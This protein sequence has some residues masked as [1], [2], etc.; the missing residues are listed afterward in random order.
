MAPQK[1][2]ASNHTYYR[3]TFSKKLPINLNIH[4]ELYVMISFKILNLK[5]G[6]II[7]FYLSTK[8]TLTTD[9]DAFS[10]RC[11]SRH[12]NASPSLLREGGTSVV[13]GKN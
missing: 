10:P 9:W 2:T 6:N 4:L 5:C 13:A 12:L 1:N 7:P 11:S 3:E 8:K